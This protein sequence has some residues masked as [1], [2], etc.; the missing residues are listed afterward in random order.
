LTFERTENRVLVKL[1]IGHPKLY[2]RLSNDDSPARKDFEPVFGPNLWYVTVHDG[3]DLLGLWLFIARSSVLWEVHTALLPC[4]WGAQGLSA[5]KEMAK[6][7][8]TEIPQ[9]HR[10]ITEVPAYNRLAVKFAERAGMT[11]YGVNPKSFQKLGKLHDLV[12]LGLSRE[13]LSP[14]QQQYH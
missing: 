3:W 8:F 9:M 13:E 12:L 2:E 4:A 14:C 10:L 7:I 6:W 5:A 1:I 11:Q